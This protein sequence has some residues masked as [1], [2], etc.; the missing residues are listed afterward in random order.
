MEPS[1][2]ASLASLAN[3]SSTSRSEISSHQFSDASSGGQEATPGPRHSST[4]ATVSKAKASHGHRESDWSLWSTSLN[5]EFTLPVAHQFSDV[6]ASSSDA[7]PPTIMKAE[8]SFKAAEAA[9]PITQAKKTESSSLLREILL[10]NVRVTVAI[11]AMISFAM[12]VG[13]AS[14]LVLACSG[15]DIDNCASSRA[16][17]V[18]STRFQVNNISFLTFPISIKLSSHLPSFQS[19]ILLSPPP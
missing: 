19:P 1:K 17:T 5:R 13:T 10:D 3:V 16:L 8:L 9:P 14:T 12:G 11:L 2:S 18:T 7:T 15:P 6:S 4:P